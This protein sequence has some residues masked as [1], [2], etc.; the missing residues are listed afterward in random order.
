MGIDESGRDTS[1]GEELAIRRTLAC[2]CHYIDDGRFADLADLFAPDGSFVLGTISATGRGEL[3]GLFEERQG[4]PQQRGRHL[5]L[6]TVIDLAGTTARAR[7]DFVFLKL[8]DGRP[9]PFVAGR[10]H[11]DLVRIDGQWRFACRRVDQWLAPE[12]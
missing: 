1:A 3:L 5:T 4:L 8:V 2:Y 9:T 11:D 10:Y 7:S 12:D 6:N